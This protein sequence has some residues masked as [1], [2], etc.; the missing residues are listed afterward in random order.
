MNPYFDLT[1]QV[2]LVTGGNSGIGLGMAHGLAKAGADVCI[3]STNVENN[4]KAAAA[5]AE[6]GTK[7]RAFRCD[8][9]DEQAVTDTF[10]ATLAEFGKVDSCFANAGVGGRGAKFQD[11]QLEELRRVFRVNVEGSFLTLRAAAAHM[12]ERGEGGVLVG[13]SSLAANVGQPRGH[14]YAAS[15]GAL[16]AIMRGLAVELARYN[17]RAHTL[18]P[19]WTHSTMTDPALNDPTFHS[20]VMPR[21]PVRRWGEG[22]DFETIAVYLASPGT[23]FHTGDTFLIDGAY[24]LF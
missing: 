5:L 19:G 18:Q 1:G 12:I 9:G 24:S 23:T 15:K 17:I 16:L 14:P 21:M 3:W 7:V 13:T 11:L 2:A 20:K 10:A 8:V 22:S 4:E 6:H